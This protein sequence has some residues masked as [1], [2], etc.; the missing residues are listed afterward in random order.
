MRILQ[1]MLTALVSAPTRIGV[2]SWLQDKGIDDTPEDLVDAVLSATGEVSSIVYAA[3]LLD[4]IEGMD[5]V[6]L[7]ALA[8][9]MPQI[10]QYML[11]ATQ[12]DDEL[13]ALEACEF[14]SA[15]CETEARV[16]RCPPARARATA[17]LASSASSSR[18]IARI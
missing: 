4:Q 1:S 13:V 3:R 8:P 15:I 17:C 14:W 7:E 16:G 12:D 9:F 18:A 10:V 6:Q 5:E 11:Q 2:L